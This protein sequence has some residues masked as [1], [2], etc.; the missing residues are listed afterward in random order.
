[1]RFHHCILTKTGLLGLMR[2]LKSEVTKF[3]ISISAVA[4]GITTTPILG[5]AQGIA[6]PEEEARKLRKTGVAVNEPEEIANVVV[7]LFGEGMKANGKGLLIQ[8]GRVAN[9]EAGLAKS[10]K[11]WMGIEQLDL[12]KGK[13]PRAV[14]E[15]L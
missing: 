5:V 11:M 2:A 8:A 10:R 12:L 15:K 13:G 4:P 9:W 1:M 3:N 14:S 6:S 7:Y